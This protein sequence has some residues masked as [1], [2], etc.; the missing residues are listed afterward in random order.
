MAACFRKLTQR[1]RG[2]SGDLEEGMCV[3]EG[4]T[5][6]KMSK[7]KGLGEVLTRIFGGTPT[8]ICTSEASYSFAILNSSSIVIIP[9]SAPNLHQHCM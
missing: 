1:C 6:R 8:V 9:P 7:R 5:G 4:V 2:L 3:G